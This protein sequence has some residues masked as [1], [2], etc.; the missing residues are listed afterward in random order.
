MSGFMKSTCGGGLLLA[1]FVAYFGHHAAAAPSAPFS[2]TVVVAELFTSEGC[3]SCPAADEVL[4]RLAHEQVVPGVDV[5]ALGEHVDYWDRLGWRDAFSSAMFS[6]RQSNYDARVFHSSQ[7]YTPQ[8]VV[9]GQYEQV[10]SNASAVRRAIVRAAEAPK[11]TVEMTAGR[12]DTGGELLATIHANVPPAVTVHDPVDVVVAVTEDNL[13]TNVR[14]GENGGRTLR[15][16][17]VVRSLTI[18]GTRP[19]QERA[20]VTNTS[21]PW[22]STWKPANVRVIGLLQ[23][24]ASRR[25]VG[26]GV[27]TL[28]QRGETK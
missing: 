11:A 27:A 5:V 21:V 10:G 8:L 28:D 19:L 12:G 3:S 13:V 6:E 9:D 7:V 23:E 16:S 22:Q 1:G 20:W 17:A 15:H 24:H 18:A 25:I 2:H 26:V 4:T 14:R